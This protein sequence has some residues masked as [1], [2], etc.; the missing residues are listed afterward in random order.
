MP[1]ANR[2][3]SGG[4][5]TAVGR[6][7]S[8]NNALKTGAYAVQVVLP[9]EDATQFAA[10]EAQLVQDF[11]P[12]GMA[13]AAMVHDLAVLTWKKLR[14]DRV[15]H[16][17]LT[18]FAL[19][20][21]LEDRLQ[22]SFGP[23][24]LPAAM[25]RMVPYTPV[26]QAEF[27]AASARMAQLQAVLDTPVSQR[28]PAALRRT[29]PLAYDTILALAEDMGERVADMINGTP[30]RQDTR[31]LDLSLEVAIDS[32]QPVL[33]LWEHR[34]RIT[35]ALQQAQDSRL[36]EYMKGSNNVT[37]R[38]FDD[39]GRTFY[40]TL[41]ELRRQQDWRIRRSAISI[42]DVTLKPPTAEANPSAPI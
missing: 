35:T 34:E 2:T 27:D 15:E 25:P 18:Q 16:A 42:D 8:A 22:R 32:M 21:L 1:I 41:A 19:L 6:A 38:A 36:L 30:A 17:V 5:K 24:W 12:V 10:L 37:Q 14:V 13:E 39:I 33:W 4:P 23:D 26:S 7:V 31:A 40:R 3:R 29:W 20:P 11:E 28:T 9:G